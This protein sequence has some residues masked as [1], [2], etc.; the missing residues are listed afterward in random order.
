MIRSCLAIAILLFAFPVH[1][2]D[3]ENDAAAGELKKL[4]GDWQLAQQEERGQPT[5][6]EVVKNLRIVIEDGEMSWYI[7][8]PASNQTADLKVDPK[9]NPKTIDAKITKNSAIRKTMLGIYKLEK[10]KLEICWADPGSEK[11]PKKFT[12]R[13]GVGAG[14]TLTVYKREKEK[15]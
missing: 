14:S 10:D 2:A 7:G 5:P 1:A 12:S 15:E 3:D 9:A 13:P 11:R 8:N 4:E 6:K